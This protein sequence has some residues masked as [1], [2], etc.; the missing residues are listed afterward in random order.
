MLNR[1]LVKKFVLLVWISW[2]ILIV[3]FIISRYY[4][5]QLNISSSMPQRLWLT[6]VGDKDV[7]RG[8][9]VVIRFHDFRM[10]DSDDFEY[11]VKQIGGIS[12]DQIIVKNCNCHTDNIPY[13]N[14]ISFSYIVTDNTYPVFESLSG[15]HFIPLTKQNMIIPKG[16]YF[17]H[18]QHHPSFDS[19]Y[20]EF[21]LI[22]E[23]QIYGKAYPIF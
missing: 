16:C 9:Y 10:Q 21:G 22:C 11:V 4:Q 17:I 20:K 2:V 6:H 8:N 15:K 13:P 19:R 18:G 7:K 3:I 5:L 1:L 23:S 12:G 14:K